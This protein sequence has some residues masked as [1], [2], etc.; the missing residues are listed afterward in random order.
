M[1]RH[2]SCDV[3]G[4]RRLEFDEGNVTCRGVDIVIATD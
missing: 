4:A 3:D 1:E 2:R